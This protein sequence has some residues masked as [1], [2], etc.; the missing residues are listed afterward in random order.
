MNFV[1]WF[2]SLWS[3]LSLKR[4]RLLCSRGKKFSGIASKIDHLQQRKTLLQSGDYLEEAW[5][6]APPEVRKHHPEIE[7]LYVAYNDPSRWV[8]DLGKNFKVSD[9]L[10]TMISEK[11]LCSVDDLDA[12]D[13]WRELQEDVTNRHGPGVRLLPLAWFRDAAATSRGT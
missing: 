3:K 1:N 8:K 5:I 4:H 10:Q 2:H 7:K 9:F 11:G 12:G 13:C 6:P